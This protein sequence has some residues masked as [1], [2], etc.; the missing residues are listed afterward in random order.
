MNMGNNYTLE[1]IAKFIS[2]YK[3]SLGIKPKDWMVG[4]PIVGRKMY[5][6]ALFEQQKREKFEKY[7][8]RAKDGSIEEQEKFI[9]QM[10]PVLDDFYSK[11]STK[12]R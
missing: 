10:T 1:D 8:M 9:E 7:F 2:D 11:K 3:E 5:Q 6:H 4:V 12:R